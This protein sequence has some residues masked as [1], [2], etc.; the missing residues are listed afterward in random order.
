MVWPES[1]ILSVALTEDSE[2]AVSVQ[3]LVGGAVQHTE[4]ARSSHVRLIPADVGG[5][6]C[7][8]IPRC[9]RHITNTDHSCSYDGLDTW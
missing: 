5:D 7:S 1:S 8:V 6:V 3:K 2:T 9:K 4:N